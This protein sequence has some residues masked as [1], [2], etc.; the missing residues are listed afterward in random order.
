MIERVFQEGHLVYLR[1]QPYRKSSL[2]YKEVEK[3]QPHFNGT[4]K[5]LRKIGEVSY[6]LEVPRERKIHN[7]FHVSFLKKA[8]GQQIILPEETSTP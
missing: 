3:L 2:K 5:I 7:V 1:L 6:E 4:Y 8:V